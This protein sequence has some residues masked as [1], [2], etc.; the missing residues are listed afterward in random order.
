[1]NLNH[2]V[3]ATEV[4]TLNGPTTAAKLSGAGIGAVA[5]ALTLNEWVAVATLVYLALQIILLFPKLGQ[6]V[7]AWRAG[8]SVEVEIK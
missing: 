3:S 7:R 4:I 5:T 2:Q 8:K 1:M 6:M